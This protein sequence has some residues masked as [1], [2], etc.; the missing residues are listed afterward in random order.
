[1]RI[2]TCL[3]A[4]TFMVAAPLVAQDFRWHGP[5]ASGKTLEVR[6]INGGIRVARAAGKEAEV[7]ATKQARKSDPASVEIKVV[8]DADGVLICA[9][10]PSRRGRADNDC[11]RSGNGRDTEDNDVQVTFDVKLPE[12]VKFDGSTVNGDVIARDLSGDAVVTTV[13]GDVEVETGGVAEATTV[14]GSIRVSLGRADWKGALRF[15]TVNG[16]ITVRLPGSFTADI[17]ATTV[18]GSVESDFPI[19]VRGRMNP[20]SLRG[21]IGEGGRDLDL[22]TVNG[23][24]RLL[25]GG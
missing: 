22:T 23:S 18:N 21:R 11:R 15:T 10:Y 14:N 4:T 13:N 12:G 3:T 1:M 16:G 7:T 19:T 17:D 6:G 9:V 24:I 20:R 5:L 25:K 8:E 2:V